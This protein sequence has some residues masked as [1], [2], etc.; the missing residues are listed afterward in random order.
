MENRNMVEP[1]S[2]VLN[3]LKYILARGNSSL[4]V[5]SNVEYYDYKD[6]LFERINW[7]AIW[8]Q[9]RNPKW[10]QR[11]LSY[12]FVNEGHTPELVA[13][14][15]D[16]NS[17]L[18]ARYSFSDF[19]PYFY[20]DGKEGSSSPLNSRDAR[21]I[22]DEK[23][24]QLFHLKSG[25]ICM[26]GFEDPKELAN[27]IKEDLPTQNL[28]LHFYVLGISNKK[29]YIESFVA[30]FETADGL[31]LYKNF[32]L[33]SFSISSVKL[34]ELVDAALAIEESDAN[35]Y[36][37]LLVGDESV[38][39]A[40]E[41]EKENPV[42]QYFRILMKR[43]LSQQNELD[44][45][46]DS[47]VLESYISGRD[48]PWEVFRRGLEWKR[49]KKH[50]SKDP[51]KTL[52]SIVNKFSSEPFRT[53]TLTSFSIAGRSGSGL[54]TVLNMLAFSVAREGFPTLIYKN[55]PGLFNYDQL[56]LFLE[57]IQ[58][59]NSGKNLTPVIIFIDESEISNMPF[60]LRELP[61]R[62][63]SDGRPVIFVRGVRITE[64]Q[65]YDDNFKSNNDLASWKSYSTKSNNV[66]WNEVLKENLDED[67]VRSLT[68]WVEGSWNNSDGRELNNLEI[69]L[70]NWSVKDET[71]QK[72]SYAP[73]LA[74]L[75]LILKEKVS[76]PDMIGG[77]IYKKIKKVSDT[78][79]S[80]SN[81]GDNGNFLTKD[82]LKKACELLE[83]SFKVKK[84]K[85][86]EV[87]PPTSEAYEKVFVS[88]AVCSVLR[89]SV[90]LSAIVDITECDINEV[91]RAVKKLTQDEL[92]S[93]T[94]DTADLFSRSTNYTDDSTAILRHPIF[95]ELF[96]NSLVSKGEQS[97]GFGGEYYSKILDV[98]KELI[99]SNDDYSYPL[100]LLEPTVKHL[101]PKSANVDFV[102]NIAMK[103]LRYQKVEGSDYHNWLMEKK[104]VLTLV[105]ILDA[106]PKLIVTNNA[107][108]LHTRGITRYKSTW[109]LYYQLRDEL[110]DKVEIVNRV[111]DVYKKSLDDLNLAFDAAKDGDTSDDSVSILTTLG[112]MYRHWSVFEKKIFCK[113]LE[114]YLSPEILEESQ[115]N[116]ENYREEAASLFQAALKIRP[117]NVHAY[118]ALSGILLDICE[119]LFDKKPKGYEVDVA[120]CLTQAFEYLQYKPDPSFQNEWEKNLDR[121][122]DLSSN[123]DA[124][125]SIR[126]LN[127]IVPLEVVG[128]EEGQKK[129]FKLL[130]SILLYEAPEGEKDSALA[131]MLRYAIFSAIP[132]NRENF[133]DRY[134]LIN[135]IDV[136][137]IS[138]FPPFLFDSA[139]LSF[140]V[141]QYN[142]GE[143]M[144]QLLRKGR[145][146]LEVPLE[147]SVFL[148]D[149][150]KK[151]VLVRKK[152]RIEVKAVYD[153]SVWGYVKSDSLNGFNSKIKIDQRLF[154]EKMG[155]KKLI[156]GDTLSANI[157]L[158]SAGPIAVPV[159]LNR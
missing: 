117:D 9:S 3:E 127:G 21:R 135:D 82:Q 33:D 99:D 30:E 64:C 88:I 50:N 34:S 14:S 137:L 138:R 147:R 132:Q 121:A 69:A 144:Y 57:S 139:M 22:R 122:V 65:N 79:A 51:Y 2:G 61:H 105:K 52:K 111:R 48:E 141:E 106:I 39:I 119:N 37:A 71:K 43:D 19:T 103:A 104:K 145:K 6:S 102:A 153:G 149:T 143:Q 148:F 53:G 91:E 154:Q 54:T 80:L 74:C 72:G 1:T 55:K 110:E 152:V 97:Q 120:E 70:K 63:D 128:S 156:N 29:E 101:S 140:Q 15:G 73:F 47:D 92:V 86:V 114:K 23:I 35:V 60:A 112:L 36:P 126:E 68:S 5:S 27:L 66:W 31:S 40:S 95:G 85:I 136:E 131:N 98:Y 124:I 76:S 84:N 87:A 62:L 146:F 45:K 7:L 158:A 58:R 93:F 28:D 4:W 67:E 142:E 41:L 116:S 118:S 46:S 94:W 10:E 77:H 17:A 157:R 89:F 125:V 155:G 78:L 159:S 8:S 44:E 26:L 150:T 18:G 133:I 20:L 13:V 56:R 25:Y 49:F 123:Q 109:D 96:L 12:R 59:K 81:S 129:L 151:G 115:K 38:N 75:Y 83:Q 32:I 130:E 108:I 134:R 90:P 16:V 24:D 107:S 42:D 113:E 100:E 11:L